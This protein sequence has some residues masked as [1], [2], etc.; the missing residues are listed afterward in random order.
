VSFASLASLVVATADLQ[1]VQDVIGAM[2][3]ADANTRAMNAGRIPPVA[4]IPAPAPPAHTDSCC[5]RCETSRHESVGVTCRPPV[6][7]PIYTESRQ[8]HWKLP[9]H[10]T[11][12]ALEPD[13]RTMDRQTA[14]IPAKKSPVQP[15]WA[16]LPWHQ[17]P[18]QI[19]QVKVV[20]PVTDIVTKGSLIDVFI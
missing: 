3:A 10:K 1:V 19:V 20:R 7:S 13:D 2:R 8:S 11:R 15:P 6:V 14:G 17:P 16:Q 5:F 4:P 18:K 9:T 12:L